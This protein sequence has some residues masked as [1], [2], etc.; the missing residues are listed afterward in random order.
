MS[1]RAFAI[2]SDQVGEN[3]LRENHLPLGSMVRAICEAA[4]AG[5]EMLYEA[6]LKLALMVDMTAPTY[7][8]GT[9]AQTIGERPNLKWAEGL[10]NEEINEA[11]QVVSEAL[12][13]TG[14]KGR[15]FNP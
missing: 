12:A 2:E 9:W 7:G 4:S 5:P 3:P 1:N 6:M 14:R 11:E 15:K 13:S 8:L 10:T